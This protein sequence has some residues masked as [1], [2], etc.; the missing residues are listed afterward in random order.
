MNVVNHTGYTARDAAICRLRDLGD[1]WVQQHVDAASKALFWIE[2]KD[3]EGELC[4]GLG[5]ILSPPAGEE[6]ASTG[7]RW[8]EWFER[9]GKKHAWASGAVAFKRCLR[10]EG[11]RKVPY[12]SIEKVAHFLPVAVEL[13]QACSED[14]PKVTKLCRDALFSV[15]SAA[16]QDLIV[17]LEAS[18]SKDDDE[19]SSGQSREEGD[20]VG[21][22]EATPTAVTLPLTTAATPTARPRGIDVVGVVVVARALLVG[23]VVAAEVELV[24]GTWLAARM[25][26]KRAPPPLRQ[27]VRRTA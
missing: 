12:L 22:G 23:V 20:A 16:R 8:I 1:V 14:S 19:E 2:L 18:S 7:E 15:V 27:G 5:F 25:R 24:T 9:K 4:V 10:L 11:R 17:D 3:P 26:K 21:G 6:P 13:C